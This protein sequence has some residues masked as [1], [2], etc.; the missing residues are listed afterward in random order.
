MSLKKLMTMTAIA[1][2][3]IAC[4]NPAK[5]DEVAKAI[6][7][8][9][10]ELNATL[11]MM[12][13]DLTRLDSSTTG[14]NRTLNYYYT[15]VGLNLDSVILVNDTA[16]LNEFQNIMYQVLL[17][18]VQITQD[19]AF[20]RENQATL[21]YQYYTSSNDFAFDVSIGPDDYADF[22]SNNSASE[23]DHEH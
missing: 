11:P 4:D 9:S 7:E 6:K 2:S 16:T 21:N 1:C 12:V 17:E 10:D 5:E 22:S 15:L 14:E 13:D 20:Y 23:H 8:S 19:M 3:L 18:N